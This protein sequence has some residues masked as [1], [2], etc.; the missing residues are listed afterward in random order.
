MCF[1]LRCLLV[2]VC[3][4]CFVACCYCLLLL[5]CIVAVYCRSL[6][7]FV[8]RCVF[9]VSIAVVVVVCCR[10]LFVVVVLLFVVDVADFVVS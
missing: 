9:F 3:L 5:L 10:L 1:R 2:D 7:R 6:L 8:A 4:F